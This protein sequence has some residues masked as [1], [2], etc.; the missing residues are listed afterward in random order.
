MAKEAAGREPLFAACMP[1]SEDIDPGQGADHGKES[2]DAVGA[3]A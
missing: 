3:V 1:G 2:P